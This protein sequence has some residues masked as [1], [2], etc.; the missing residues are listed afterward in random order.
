M[1]QPRDSLEFLSCHENFEQLSHAHMHDTVGASISLSAA[2]LL[3]HKLGQ[4]SLTDCNKPVAR[5]ARLET[6]R[7]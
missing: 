2:A 3:M 5:G 7:D 1:V 4:V 6:P